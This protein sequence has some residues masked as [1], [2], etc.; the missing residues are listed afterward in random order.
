MRS[1][2]GLPTGIMRAYCWRLRA[3]PPNKPLG[4]TKIKSRYAADQGAG[5]HEHLFK[6]FRHV[7]AKDKNHDE[8]QSDKHQRKARSEVL[9]EAET[10]GLHRP[11]SPTHRT[12][13]WVVVLRFEAMLS[14]AHGTAF[15]VTC[16]SAGA[17]GSAVGT[18]ITIDHCIDW[19]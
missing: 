3:W 17:G 13:N 5:K 1:A 18:W 10:D 4:A 16:I 15:A 14:D 6:M 19:L 2:D 8:S 12:Y 9:L 11:D 7:N